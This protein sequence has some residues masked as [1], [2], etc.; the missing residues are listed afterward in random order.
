MGGPGTPGGK[1][2]MKNLRMMVLLILRAGLAT[3]FIWAGLAKFPDPAALA[4]AVARFDLLPAWLINPFSLALPV[5]EILSGVGLLIGPWP[6]QFAFNLACL[7]GIFLFALTSAWI[8]GIKIECSCFGGISSASLPQL[9]IR[10]LLLLCA[11]IA[12]YFLSK[13]MK[14]PEMTGK[15]ICHPD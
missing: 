3:V 7:N 11:S 6:R 15:R 4:H 8:R 5:F 2:A 13:S 14:S 1:I 12:V 10:D 9:V